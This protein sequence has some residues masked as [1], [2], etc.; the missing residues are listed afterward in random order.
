MMVNYSFIIPHHNSPELLNRCIASIPQREDLEIIVVDD[1]SDDD[2]KPNVE[3]NDVQIVLL[4]RE[5]S[6]GAGRARNVG[7][8]LAK[9]KWLLFADCDD[10]YVEDFMKVLDKLVNS[11]YDVIYFNFYQYL[12]GKNEPVYE[13]VSN[14]IKECAEGKLDI[15]YV[16]YRNNTPWNKM[17][18]NHFVKEY[19][20]EFEEVPIANDMFFSFQIGY[21]CK[22]YLVTNEYLYNY[23]VYKK[24]QTRRNWNEIKIKA[25]IDHVQKRN[26]FLHIVR[27][28]EWKHGL[29]FLLYQ[30]AKL[31]GIT[32]ALKGLFVY[33]KHFRSNLESQSLYP[34]IINHK[35]SNLRYE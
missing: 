33:L 14:Y 34:N 9:G 4:N 32:L 26:G 20:I 2:K 8:S 12:E 1:N 17:V 5:Q 11:D 28:D 16:K 15:D 10:Y 7:L 24:S 35:T 18:K 25:Y 27:H 31:G 3:R 30:F 23:I 22:K 29:I 19:H 6:K 21:F 13:K